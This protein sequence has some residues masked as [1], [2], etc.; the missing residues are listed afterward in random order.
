MTE[1]LFQAGYAAAVN[2]E[3]RAPVMSKVFMSATKGL[4]IGEGSLELAQAWLNGYDAYVTESLMAL[5]AD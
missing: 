2:N 5:M 3:M 4:K 1:Q